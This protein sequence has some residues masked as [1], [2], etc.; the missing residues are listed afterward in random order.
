MATAVAGTGARGGIERPR[1]FPRQLVTP[2]DLTLGQDYFRDRLRRMNRYLHGW[3]VVCGARVEAS[4]Q[5]WRVVVHPGYLLGPQGDEIVIERDVCFDLRTRC[6]SGMG[7]DACDDIAIDPLRPDRTV[8]TRDPGAPLFVAVRYRQVAA[9]PVRVQPVGCGCD[10][11]GC[12]FSRWQDGYELCVLDACPE[13]HAEP[14]SHEQ[15]LKP[16]SIPDCPACTTD[17]WLVLAKVVVDT[18]G[19][20]SELDNCACRRQL[21]TTGPYWWTCSDPAQRKTEQ[22]TETAMDPTNSA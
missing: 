14:P 20:V 6:V 17:P 12:E 11:T 8:S 21:R 4:Q 1:F 22:A 9:R 13:S 18:Q 7:S 5:P 3:G 10:D 19:R 16:G 15:F 2:D